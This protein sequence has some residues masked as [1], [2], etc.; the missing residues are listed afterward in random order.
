[1]PR[2]RTRH[3]HRIGAMQLAIAVLGGLAIITLPSCGGGGS[4]LYR[5]AK[6]GSYKA[7][8]RYIEQGEDINAGR[9]GDGRTPLH[10]ASE[11]GH[12]KVVTVLVN[13]GA[14][15]NARDNEGNTPL[16]LAADAG[17][18]GTVRILLADGA[19]ATIR[20]DASE[21]PRDLAQGHPKVT[22]DL[23]NAGG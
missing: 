19:D 4:S 14:F 3:Q 2:R 1:M 13:H 16:H 23:R 6:S 8:D 15:V 12:R 17:H 20:N 18:D 11:R 21:T 9:A 5:A 22:R 10:A 7:A